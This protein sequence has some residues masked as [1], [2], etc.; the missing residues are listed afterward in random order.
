MLDIGRLVLD[1][2]ENVNCMITFMGKDRAAMS[3]TISKVTVILLRTELFENEEVHNRHAY[4]ISTKTI[5]L[6]VNFS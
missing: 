3:Y 1:T 6:I 5:E 4:F 2:S